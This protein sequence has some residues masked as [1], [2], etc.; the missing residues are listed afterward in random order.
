[1]KSQK[2]LPTVYE[3]S[4]GDLVKVLTIDGG[5]EYKQIKPFEYKDIKNREYKD[6]NQRYFWILDHY[7]YVPDSEVKEIMVIGL[8]MF[9]EEVDKLV[10]GDECIFPLDSFFPAPD[11]LLSV[12]KEAVIKDLATVYK[13]IIPDVKPNNNPDDKQ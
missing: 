6:A 4:Y 11:Y 13:R 5:K 12:V 9:H 8:F 3:S 10:S 7:I 2:Q 1:M